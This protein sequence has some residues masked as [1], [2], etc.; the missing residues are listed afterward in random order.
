MNINISVKNKIFSLF[1]IVIVIAVSAVGW[2][3]FKSAKESY[4]NSALSINEGETRALSNKT[5]ATLEAVPKDLLYSANFYA[6]AKLLVW[7]DLKDKR[8]IRR[9]KNIYVSALKDYI[10]HKKIYYQVHILDVDGNEKILLKY[11]EKTNSIMETSD[12]KLQNKSDRKYFQEAMKIKKGEF[13]ISVM[14]LNIE[15]GMIEK[16]FVP[17]VR[18]STPLINDN[19]EIKGV[20]V[21]NFSASY[22]LDEIAKA[23]TRDSRNYYLINE[24]GFY[25]YIGDKA[26]RWGFQLGSDYNFKR[27][28][29]GVIEEFKDK[30]EITF[31]KKD[32]IFSMHKVYPNKAENK[33]RFWYLV[34]EIDKDIALASLDTFINVFFLILFVVLGFGLFFINSYI[35]KLMNPLTKVTTQLKALSNGE[36]KKEQI[37]YDS[38]DEIGQIVNSTTILVDA[39]E[40]TIKQAN[41]VANGDFTKEM[42]LLSKNDSLGLAII[43]MTERL[44]EITTLAEKLSIG[45]YD[46]KI[47]PKSGDDKLGIALVDMISY[48]KVVTSVAESIAEGK[49]DVEYK[50]VGNDDRLGISMLKM[51]SYLRGILSQADAITKE[52]FTHTI[53]IKS[54]DDELGIAL[55][56]M[57]EMLENNSIKN[58]DEIYFSDGVGEFSDKLSGISDTFELSKHAIT[59]ACRYVGASS[60]VVYTLN[61]ENSELNLIAS[62]AFV[63]RNN[64]SNN[65]KIGEGIIGQVG[66]EREP[67]LLK[68]IKDESYEVQ[69]GTTISKPKEIFT[70]PLIHESE[71]FGVVE[72]MS[73][74]SFSKIHQEYLLKIASILAT[75]LY[76]ATQN[77]QIKTLLEDSKR[78]YEELQVQSEELQESNVQMEEQQQQLT[79]QAK[80]MKIKNDE[81]IQAKNDLDKRADDL[82]KASRYKSEFLA[83]MSHELRTPLNSIILLSKL[84]TQNQNNTLSESDVSKTSVIHKAGNDL[85]L[86][87]NDI[88][89]LSKIESGNMELSEN[90]VQTSE[91]KDEIQGL[92]SEVANDKKIGFEIE[93]NFKNSFIVDKMKLLQIIKNLLSNAFKFTKDGRVV[94]SLNKKNSNIV[95]EITDSGIGIPKAKLA[96]IFE[97]FKQV[98]GSI[99]REYGGTG[100]GLSISKTFIDLMGGTIEVESKE[101]KGSTFRV[102]V[103]LQKQDALQEIPIILKSETKIDEI[104]ATDEAQDEIFDS[105]LLSGKNILIVDDDSRNIFTLS[106]VVQE[107]GAETY[108]ALNGDDAFKLLE[109][110]DA[111]M[112]VILM[113][114]M[115]PIM[116]GLEAIKKIKEDERFKHIPIIAVTAKTMKEDKEKCYKAG[117]NDYLP[118]PIDQNAL[119]SMLKAWCK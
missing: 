37:I 117:A 80:D 75:S 50:A 101:G 73:F 112:D 86:L 114:I 93:D 79:L 32:K 1:I 118:K 109:D 89:D 61:K 119:I 110:E 2:F 68:N 18:Y 34:A 69:S 115:M 47:M 56:K 96:L 100:L 82:E 70:F 8:K 43:D 65:F 29:R 4:I 40:T 97:A 85:L 11:D 5:Q 62:F 74:D 25:L 45:N 57:T 53:K 71:L 102:I 30:D 27:D 58:R 77:M 7:E 10:L 42:Q 99:S 44:K 14:N 88:L 72:I 60:G 54:K 111:T 23:E 104:L 28:F 67:I 83:N 48:L 95:I 59:V 103:P 98:D 26:K 22:I 64:L 51:I 76:A 39:I 13:Y 92:F 35:S 31:I 15:N 33:Y 63:E 90:V 78:A 9:L 16:P 49:I 19:G 94:M 106:S 105:E 107:L 52:D 91:I 24:D 108:S 116:D 20:I 6:L 17:V 84:L 12:S 113:D 3:G 66:L 46:T 21:L 38:N 81:L 36:I 41:A 55:I 87:I